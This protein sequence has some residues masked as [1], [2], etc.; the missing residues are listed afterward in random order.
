MKALVWA[1]STMASLAYSV[2]EV[3]MG[4]LFVVCVMGEATFQLS[5][6]P[7]WC[8]LVKAFGASASAYA[9]FILLAIAFEFL[10]TKIDEN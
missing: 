3:S 8:H 5:G 10:R 4:A 6:A 9:A 2:A 7:L 1:S